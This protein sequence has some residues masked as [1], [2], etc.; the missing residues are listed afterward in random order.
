MRTNVILNDELIEKAIQLGS[1]K[2][3]KAAIEAGLKLLIQIKS[4]EKLR[5]LRG[6]LHWEGDL[7]K[8]RAGVM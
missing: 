8:M 6:K 1:F 7:E 2:T 4:Q 3:R 5:E